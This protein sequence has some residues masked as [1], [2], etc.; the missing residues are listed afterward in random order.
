M[1]WGD[2]E[3]LSMEDDAHYHVVV[4]GYSDWWWLHIMQWSLI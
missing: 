4:A 3:W 2:I 1:Y